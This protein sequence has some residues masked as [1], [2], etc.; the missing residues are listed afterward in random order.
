VNQ[1]VYRNTIKPHITAMKFA[2]T[3]KSCFPKLKLSLVILDISLHS[4]VWIAVVAGLDGPEGPW[5]VF[6][7]NT[8][9]PG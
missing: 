6:C 8:P 1:K 3:K 9:K 4:P 2:L 5:S 7:I